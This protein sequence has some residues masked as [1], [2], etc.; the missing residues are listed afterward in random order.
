MY[1]KRISF[2]EAQ[3]I[4]LEIRPI[5][6]PNEGFVEQLELFGKMG[7]KL[8]GDSEFHSSIHFKYAQDHNWLLKRMLRI[9][10][11]WSEGK[12]K[13]DRKKNLKNFWQR[14]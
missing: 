10:K 8:A 11:Q 4:L 5:I 3:N 2:S 13:V 7:F 14:N 9:S 1:K 12:T 6:C